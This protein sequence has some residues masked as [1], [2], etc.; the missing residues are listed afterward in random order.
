M[1]LYTHEE[2][3]NGYKVRLLASFLDIELELIR[4]DLAGGEQ[5]G[6]DF[7]AINPR[8]EVPV[9]VDGARV[10][11]DSSA[12]LVYLAARTPEAGWWSI[13]AH[14]QALIVEWLSFAASW[15]Q[16]GVFT[17]RSVISFH[18][19]GNGLPPDFPHDVLAESNIRATK[20]LAILENSLHKS[21]WLACGRPT[22]A[23]IA[24]FPYVALAPMGG[25]DLQPY[26]SVRS[27]IARFRALV[28]F[29]PILG[30]D[31][32]HYQSVQKLCS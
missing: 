30:L 28:G 1:R 19:P 12:I 6:D 9:L 22:I 2:S 7:V 29:I 10:L 27:W 11:R 5:R 13:C 20:S 32:P 23:D 14:E 31:D 17:M 16:F 24:V 25:V 26:K 18:N 8:G 15:I 3:G 21:D 4:I